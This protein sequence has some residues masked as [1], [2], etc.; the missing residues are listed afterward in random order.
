LDADGLVKSSIPIQFLATVWTPQATGNMVTVT[1][2]HNR[3][4]NKYHLVDNDENLSFIWGDIFSHD[5][6]KHS[7]LQRTGRD[8]DDNINP[9]TN[10]PYYCDEPPQLIYPSP[11]AG[12][13]LQVTGKITINLRAM[14]YENL[15]VKYD[16]NRFQYN[17]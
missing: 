17:S 2:D 7:K 9:F 6:H 8:T 14:Y 1:R 12:V 3:V 15:E 4:D 10:N 11:E 5:D 13:E 16:L